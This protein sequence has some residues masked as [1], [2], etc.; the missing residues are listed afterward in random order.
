MVHASVD[1][2]ETKD[3][4]RLRFGW[5][6]PTAGDMRAFGDPSANIPPDLDH[7]TR[8]AHAAEDAGLEYAL[9]PVQT[10]C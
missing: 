9:V 8:V 3:N 2:T 5:F 7:F 4:G 1:D 10:M 6:I